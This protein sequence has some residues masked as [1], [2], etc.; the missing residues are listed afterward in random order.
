MIGAN[1]VT[2]LFQCQNHPRRRVS[3]PDRLLPAEADASPTIP[4]GS[5]PLEGMPAP[6]M[7]DGSSSRG[8][9]MFRSSRLS[10]RLRV[11]GAH[12]GRRC[13]VMARR[14][15]DT[16]IGVWLESSQGRL[17]TRSPPLAGITTAAGFGTVIRR[18]GDCPIRFRELHQMISLKRSGVG[19]P[20]FFVNGSHY[21]AFVL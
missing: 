12:R 2:M 6:R 11:T 9:G 8:A 17:G 10:G 19:A 15:L 21:P 4:V 1:W 3:T 18:F 7:A 5:F 14:G 16:P 13:A 20:V